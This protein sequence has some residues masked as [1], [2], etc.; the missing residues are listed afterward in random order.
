MQVATSSHGVVT[1]VNSNPKPSSKMPQPS[2][3]N[4]P[5]T[6]SGA[7]VGIPSPASPPTTSVPPPPTLGTGKSSTGLRQPGAQSRIGDVKLQKSDNA[8]PATPSRIGV[9]SGMV[10]K[11]EGKAV[12]GPTSGTAIPTTG[13]ATPSRLQP[14]SSFGNLA[15]KASAVS[16]TPSSVGVAL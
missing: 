12:G 6:L 5:R 4:R 8:P 15:R 14:P 1:G 10:Y 16:L 13:S 2:K 11:R 7:A 9:G 3:S